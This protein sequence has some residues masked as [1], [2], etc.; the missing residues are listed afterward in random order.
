MQDIPLHFAYANQTTPR[1]GGQAVIV[2]VLFFLIIAM[3]VILGFVSPV[4]GDVTLANRLSR[5][6]QS[7]FL[8]ESVAEDVTFRLNR[9]MEVSLVEILTIAGSSAIATITNIPPDRKEVLATAN[10][11]GL[12]R[13]AQIDLI[14]GSGAAFNFGIQSGEGGILM[15]NTSSVDGN[16]FS[17]GPVVATNDNLIK[18][19]VISAGPNGLVDGV[20]ATSSV[21]AHT[22]S[23]AQVDKDAYYQVISNTTVLGTAFPGSPDQATSILP[24]PDAL[25]D[26]WKADAAAGGVITAPCPYVIDTVATIGPVK[27][28]CDLEIQKSS[29]DV[30]IA[31]A[32]WVEGNIIT[33]VGQPTIRAAS[34]LGSKSVVMIADNP[35]DRSTSS[36]IELR[37]SAT[38]FNSGTDGSYILLVSQNNDAENSGTEKAIDITQSASGDVLVYAGHGNITIAQS[39][40]LKEVTAYKITLTQSAEVI[41][42][43][44][45]TSLLFTGGPSG[46]F[47]IIGW[48]EVE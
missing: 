5:S 11:N 37:N 22:I 34:S 20:Y 40:S 42:E 47:E 39:A 13:S 14:V 41:Y 28:E 21:Y 48:E 4:L 16:A 10:V 31:G 3:T 7:I 44:G 45:L 32:V 30:T 36:K 35:S 2:A 6:K 17:N 25:I 29:A 23:N 43:T 9:G 19:D 46:G 27:I 18:G 26:Q 1:Q 8:A 38:F 24:I 12:V 33:D 15:A